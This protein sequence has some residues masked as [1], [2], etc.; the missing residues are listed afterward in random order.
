[1][2]IKVTEFSTIVITYDVLAESM[3]AYEEGDFEYVGDTHYGNALDT[4]FNSCEIVD[5][6]CN[7][8]E[9]YYKKQQNN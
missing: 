6:N 5:E 7:S 4:Q 9:E 3:E 1:M 2:I 8:H